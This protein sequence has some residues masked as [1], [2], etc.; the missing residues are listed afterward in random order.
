MVTYATVE[1][2]NNI[3]NK[4]FIFCYIGKDLETIRKQLE[5]EQMPTAKNNIFPSAAGY[6]FKFDSLT[7]VTAEEARKYPCDYFD[8]ITNKVKE[9]KKDYFF[10]GSTRV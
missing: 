4:Q 8:S 6:M 1:V 5:I 3:S 7:E 10:I 2:E 9:G